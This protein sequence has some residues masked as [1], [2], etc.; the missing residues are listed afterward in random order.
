MAPR[1]RSA[2]ALRHR[3]AKSSC[4]FCSPEHEIISVLLRAGTVTPCDLGY[5]GITPLNALCLKFCTEEKLFFLV[6]GT[7]CISYWAYQL[8]SLP[9]WPLE[10]FIQ[11]SG[12]C[13]SAAGPGDLQCWESLQ[14][15]LSATG[16]A[17]PG[18]GSALHLKIVQIWVSFPMWT[19]RISLSPE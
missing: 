5:C 12:D 3:A 9:V 14:S 8:I 1:G 7:L 18:S 16:P 6:T 19:C 4:P 11:P 17:A 15:P 10:K 2:L 13:N